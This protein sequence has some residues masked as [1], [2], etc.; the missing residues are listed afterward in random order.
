M[1]VGNYVKSVL[2]NYYSY[3]YIDRG[4]HPIITNFKTVEHLMELG[5][6][7]ILFEFKSRNIKLDKRKLIEIICRSK[8]YLANEFDDLDNCFEL[9]NLCDILK[10]TCELIAWYST[11]GRPLDEP[12]L[13]RLVNDISKV[14]EADVTEKFAR[15]Y[16]DKHCTDIIQIVRHTFFNADF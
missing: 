10:S 11:I 16:F 2:K 15:E 14:V 3:G 1:L 4:Y 6:S 9:N 12:S 13:N 8:K 7:E 5:I